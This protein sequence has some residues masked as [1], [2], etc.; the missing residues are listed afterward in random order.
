MSRREVSR[1]ST[2]YADV[3]LSGKRF[4]RIAE[5]LLFDGYRVAR[6]SLWRC[7]DGTFIARAEWRKAKRSADSVRYTETGIKVA[8]RAT[9][10][11]RA[12]A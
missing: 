4:D 9:E 11:M 6:A 7:A 10:G 1:I 8:I 2:E 12:V 3:E 5:S